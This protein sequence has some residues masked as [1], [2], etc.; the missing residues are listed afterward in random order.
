MIVEPPAFLKVDADKLRIA[1]RLYH[2]TSQ[3]FGLQSLRDKRVKI[4]RFQELNDPFDFIGLAVPY[5]SQRKYLNDMKN[6]AYGRQGMVC[7]STSWKEPLLWGHY[8]DK[9]RGMCLGFDVEADDW[10]EVIYSKERPSLDSLCV[11]TVLD[12]SKSQWEK[13]FRTKFKAWEYEREYR[14]FINLGEPD[15]VSGLHFHSFSERMKLARVIIGDRSTIDESILKRI[16]AL[17]GENVEVFQA[18]PAFRTF[19]V[20]KRQNGFAWN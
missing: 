7:M 16:R 5:P 6:E 12:I 11:Q 9:H 14:H 18:R 3:Q 17:V 10:Q 20:V 4:A 19:E 2:F 13:L 15:L 1:M 8:A